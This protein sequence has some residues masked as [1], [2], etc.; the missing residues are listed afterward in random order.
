MPSVMRLPASQ[1][2]HR[3]VNAIDAEIC[4]GLGKKHGHEQQTTQE[5]HLWDP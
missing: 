4:S 3:N 5:C 2:H 1:D